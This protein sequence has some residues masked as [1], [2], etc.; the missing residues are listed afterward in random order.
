[1]AL[2]LS[3][4]VLTIKLRIRIDVIGETCVV[5]L[6]KIRQRKEVVRWIDEVLRG[7]IEA[8]GVVRGSAVREGIV[9]QSEDVAWDVVEQLP[10][11]FVVNPA[12]IPNVARAGEDVGRGSGGNGAAGDRGVRAVRTRGRL[13]LPAGS[14]DTGQQNG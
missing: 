13:R 4:V 1:M 8:V 2:A 3:R 7:R 11:L 5:V 14:E 6:R 12:A 10:R 9:A